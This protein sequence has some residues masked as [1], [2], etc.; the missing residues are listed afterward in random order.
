MFWSECCVVTA[1]QILREEKLPAGL[2]IRQV[3]TGGVGGAIGQRGSQLS[4]LRRRRQNL[5]TEFC[6]V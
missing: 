3:M 1:V 4:K 6:H 5:H 2:G